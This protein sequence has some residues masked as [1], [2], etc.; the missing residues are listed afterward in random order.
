MQVIARMIQWW[1]PCFA[2][3]M[4]DAKQIIASLGSA[5]EYTILA[6]N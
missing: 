4:N 3:D 1:R 6:L 2:E 5:E